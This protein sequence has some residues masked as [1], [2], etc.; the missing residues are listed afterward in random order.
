MNAQDMLDLAFGQ[1]DG[2]AR[3]QAEAELT[4]DPTLS[5]RFDRLG[6]A[7]NQLLDD[8]QV[9]E[10]PP[11]LARRTLA[12][13][14]E[15]RRRRRTLLDYV[16]VKVPFRWADVAV[17]AG[18]LIAGL[19]TLAPA[20]HRSRDRMNQAACVFN[21]QRLGLG[22]AQ[23]G[24][25]N[26]SYPYTHPDCPQATV[27]TFA[28]LLHDSGLLDDLTVLDCPSNGACQHPH[29]ALPDLKALCTLKATDPARYL[30]LM[31]WD[32]AYHAGY[33]DRGGEA[34]SLATPCSSTVPLLADQPPHQTD[35]QRILPG[36]S[37]NHRGVGQNVLF[38]DLHVDWHNTRS[39]GPQ[40]ADM[41]LNDANQPG[42]GL[43]PQD[44]VLLPSLFPF[45]R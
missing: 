15:N 5:E 40:D 13:V 34:H 38:S 29:M 12:Y 2:A 23:Y 4:S 30:A 1:L 9:I 36:N 21:L 31:C 41:F 17:A 32:Y 6:R 42:P 18:I 44:A 7:I 8:G 45:E 25:Q 39:L 11:D 35:P 3:S 19:L 22:L 33:R 20:I 27:G 26:R 14:A 10:A 16:P 43:D 37:P 28:A 24:H